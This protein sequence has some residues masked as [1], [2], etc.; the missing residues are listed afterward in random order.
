[1]SGGY[2]GRILNID[3]NKKTS[4]TEKTNLE[5]AKSYIGAKGLGA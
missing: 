5:D 3:L 4:K 2:T 1:M